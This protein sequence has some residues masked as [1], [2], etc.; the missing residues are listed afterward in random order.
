[1]CYLSILFLFLLF[2]QCFSFLPL[3]LVLYHPYLCYLSYSFFFF[4]FLK[5]KTAYEMRIIY[6]SSDVCSSDLGPRSW[7]AHR[8]CPRRRGCNGAPA[9]LPRQSQPPPAAAGGIRCHR[10]ARCRPRSCRPTAARNRRPS[11]GRAR[12]PCRYPWW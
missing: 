12:C 5:Q 11:T 1:M 9:L 4:F 10:Q 8:D 6:W 3:G 2:L 7:S